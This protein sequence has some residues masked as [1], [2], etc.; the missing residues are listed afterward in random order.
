[1]GISHYHVDRLHGYFFY[2]FF[3]Y[4]SI[5]FFFFFFFL[6]MSWLHFLWLFVC[7]AL[8]AGKTKKIESKN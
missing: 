8:A 2:I 1:M 6:Q 4:L 5:F 3:I 7:S